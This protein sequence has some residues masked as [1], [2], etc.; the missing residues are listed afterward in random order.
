MPSKRDMERGQHDY[1]C[2]G[3]MSVTVWCD[4]SSIYFISTF[5]DPRV[6]GSVN[7]KGK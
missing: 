3:G 1:L 4:R 6:V 5:H 2:T 7:R